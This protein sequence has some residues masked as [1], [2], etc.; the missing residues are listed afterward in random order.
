MDGDCRDRSFTA[1]QFVADARA[2]VRTRVMLAAPGD[3]VVLLYDDGLDTIAGL[4]GCL[5]AGLA[6]VSGIHPAAPR[7]SERLLGILR[8]SGATVVLGQARVLAQFQR[9]LDDVL[10]EFDLRWVA[11]DAL[12]HDPSPARVG[13]VPTNDTLALVQYTSGSTREPRGVM[14]THRNILHNLDSQLRPSATGRA[15]PA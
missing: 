8:D 11:S 9:D 3:R 10:D 13:T 1:G 5:S 2:I 7:S 6:A 4:F 15:T 14:L 12:R